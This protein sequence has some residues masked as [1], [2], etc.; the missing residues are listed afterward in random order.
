MIDKK[1]KICQNTICYRHSTIK[2]LLT[3]VSKKL[4]SGEYNLEDLITK[5][6]EA[7]KEVGLAKRSGQ[8]MENRLRRYR[9]SIEN[10]G[11]VKEIL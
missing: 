9:N 10:L 5:L 1:I 8:H 2:Y 4:K 6:N 11:F 7:I 3:Y